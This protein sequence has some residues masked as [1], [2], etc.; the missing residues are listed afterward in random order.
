MTSTTSTRKTELYRG[1]ELVADQGQ[2]KGMAWK[3]GGERLEVGGSE[4]DGLLQAL[5]EQ[6]DA[7]NPRIRV[8]FQPDVERAP[9][10]AAAY[11]EAFRRIL[12]R[13]GIAP[14]Y[15][16]MLRGIFRAPDHQMTDSQLQ[17]TGPFKQSNAVDLHFG[18]LG[19]RVNEALL[20]LGFEVS[21]PA[22]ADGTPNFAHLVARN[23]HPG[24]SEHPSTWQLHPETIAALTACG[25]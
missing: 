18:K 20:D 3:K 4:V 22:R 21:L 9:A 16:A 10:L 8:E 25:L 19:G 7:V 23:I 2:R 24:D 1:Y 5:R 12:A 15:L 14:S 13:K 6:I 11:L 17:A